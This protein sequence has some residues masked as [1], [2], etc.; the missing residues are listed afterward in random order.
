MRS[1]VVLAGAVL[2]AGVGG[3]LVV[4]GRPDGPRPSTASSVAP[5][6]AVPGRSAALDVLHA[7]DDARERAWA[8]GDPVALR[9]L[10]A[11]GSSAGEH[12]VR[13]LRRYLAR[14][15]VVRH[16]ERQVLASR[17]ERLT[18]DRIR[19]VVTD[20][21]AGGMASAGSNRVA[22]PGTSATTRVLVLR[23]TDGVWQVV[24]VRQPGPP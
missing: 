5:V 11:A 24:S 10:Y 19:L 22:L 2:V 6:R 13:L 3:L 20:R 1:R 23:R 14:G 9:R 8:S 18:A 15:V 17:V 16:M 21:F 4:P 12:D 7:W